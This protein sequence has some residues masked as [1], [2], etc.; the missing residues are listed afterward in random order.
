MVALKRY[1]SL[2]AQTDDGSADRAFLVSKILVTM[3]KANSSRIESIKSLNMVILAYLTANTFLL[4]VFMPLLC[5]SWRDLKV[6]A[7]FLAAKLQQEG[8][9]SSDELAELMETTQDAR[10]TLLYRSLS[11]FFGLASCAPGTCWELYYSHKAFSSEYT[12][13]RVVSAFLSQGV[14]SIFLNIRLQAKQQADPRRLRVTGHGQGRVFGP[15]IPL[16]SPT[17]TLEIHEKPEIIQSCY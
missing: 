11:V 9:E 14:I 16:H 6:K 1:L 5:I 15:S 7:E 12:Y 17:E 13:Y 10:A 8:N 3:R 4:S 2:V